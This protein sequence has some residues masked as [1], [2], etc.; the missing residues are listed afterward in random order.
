MKRIRRIRERIVLHPIITFCILILSIV[1]ISGILTLF[2]VSTTYNAIS[3]NGTYVKELV[4]VENL[5]SLSGLKFIFSNAVSNFASFTPLSMLIITLFGIGIM[6][7]TGFLDSFFYVLTK[8]GSKKVVTFILSLI[9]I[10]SSIGGDLSYIVL[11]P[12]SA[13]LFKYGKRHP[14]AGI[15]CAFAGLSCGIGINIFMSSIDSTLMG[16]S[17]LSA[18]LLVKDYTIGTHSY[19]LIM[20]L[21]AVALAFINTSITEKIIVPKLGHYEFEDEKEDYLTKKEKKG[22]FISL[23]SGIIYILFFI[24]NIIPYAPLGGNFLDYSQKLYIDKL[25]GYNSFFSQGFVF[26]VTLLF[27]ILGLTYGIA[28]KSIKNQKDVGEAL[29]YSLDKIGKVLVLIFFASSLIFIFKKTNI[30]N[31]ITA[32]FANIISNSNFTGIPLILLLLITSAISTIV[33]PGSVNK[34]A[35]LS[36]SV[37]PVFM[38]AGLSAEFATVIFRAGEC[39]TYG[40]TPVMAYFVIYLAF[41]ELYNSENDDDGL[42]GNI[43]YIVPYSLSTFVMWIA[44]LILFYIIG[45]PLGF[46]AFP[47]L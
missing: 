3:N 22:L 43:K 18:N 19:I 37:V 7:R 28:T 11:I 45:M 27:F 21:S 29:S 39:I 6:D 8:N 44:I 31:V 24:Y 14:K 12:M 32:S 34:W 4:K 9:C 20:L 26:V 17:V 30:G 33:L 2:N 16:Y 42:F 15:I 38:N 25:F 10:I 5:F 13:L 1:I 36:G 35:I 40:L 41:M 23:F 46:G 47:G